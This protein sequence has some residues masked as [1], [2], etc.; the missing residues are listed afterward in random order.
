MPLKVLNMWK[1]NKK[2]FTSFDNEVNIVLLAVFKGVVLG[3]IG[4]IMLYLIFEK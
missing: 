3:A 4:L 2:K 1:N